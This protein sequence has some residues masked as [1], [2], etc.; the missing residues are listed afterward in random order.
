MVHGVTPVTRGERYTIVTWFT[1]RPA[2][3]DAQAK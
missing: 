3:T 1:A 2:E